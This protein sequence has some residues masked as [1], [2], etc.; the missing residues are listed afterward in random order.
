MPLPDSS[1][2]SRVRTIS[3]RRGLEGWIRT[4][5]LLALRIEADGRALSPMDRLLMALKKEDRKTGEIGEKRDRRGKRS[6]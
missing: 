1:S 5:A 3:G 4:G 2:E 6:D